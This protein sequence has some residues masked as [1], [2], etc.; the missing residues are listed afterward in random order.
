MTILRHG[1]AYLE[2]SDYA[3]LRDAA[4]DGY[5]RSLGDSVVRGP[6]TARAFWSFHQ[7]GMACCGFKVSW[8]LVAI[9][10]VATALDLLLNPKSTAEGLWRRWRQR[11]RAST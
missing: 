7:Q 5:H 8:R 10:A 2:P 3:R 1:Q 11:H 9:Y 6:G 4:T